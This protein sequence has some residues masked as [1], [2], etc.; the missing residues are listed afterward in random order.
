MPAL[1]PYHPNFLVN[2]QGR[3]GDLPLRIPLLG[4]ILENEL[5]LRFTHLA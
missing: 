5:T 1:S 3:H 2:E 4:R